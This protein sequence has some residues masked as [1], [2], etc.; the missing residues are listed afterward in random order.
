MPDSLR[1][2]DASPI[3]ALHAVIVFLCA[4]AL[5]I[6]TLEV[7]IGTALSAIFSAPPYSMGGHALSLVLSALYAGAAVGALI[8]G[9]A[10]HRWGLPRVL[11]ACLLW[12]GF[13]TFRYKERHRI[14]R[15]QI[16]VRD[17]HWR[18]TS[19]ADCLSHISRAAAVPGNVYLFD[20]RHLRIGASGDGLRNSLAYASTSTRDRG[21]PMAIRRRRH[22]GDCR[23]ALFSEATGVASMANGKGANF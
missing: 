19:T 22:A 1:R 4:L 9:A 8:F 3:T 17:L 12:L 21:I 13:W 10:A 23:R 18:F 14:C 16:F 20:V 7:S 15:A 5:S 6:D 11:S 2:L